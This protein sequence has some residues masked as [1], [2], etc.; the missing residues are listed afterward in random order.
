LDKLLQDNPV[1]WRSSDGDGSVT[2]IKT[3]FDALDAALPGGGWP[4][5]AL[6]EILSEQ[7][8]IGEL[9]LVMPALAR[10]GLN[11]RWQAWIAPPYDPYPPA[12]LTAGVDLGSTTFVRP[13]HATAALWATEKMLGSGTCDAV[14]AWPKNSDFRTLRRLQL[15]A[16]QGHCWGILFRAARLASQP[17]PA[18]LRLHLCTR[19]DGLEVQILKARGTC[20]YQVVHLAF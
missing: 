13:G 7:P 2:S 20:H 3:G 9:R 14:L 18:A 5:G 8:G 15:A 6:T 10:L 17:S 1:L 4:G 12:L 11:G 19:D 16:K